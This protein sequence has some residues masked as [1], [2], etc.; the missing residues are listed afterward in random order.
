MG[1]LGTG[2]LGRW[3]H[4]ARKWQSWD[5]NLGGLTPKSVLS[6]IS[7]YFASQGKDERGTFSW[8]LGAKR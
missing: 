1:K 2:L 8:I 4:S 3:Q 7:L 6:A 5:L